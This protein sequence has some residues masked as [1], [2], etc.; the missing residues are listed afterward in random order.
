M[1]HFHAKID[2]GMV[3]W[4]PWGHFNQNRLVEPLN[5]SLQTKLQNGS[6]VLYTSTVSGVLHTHSQLQPPEA[7]H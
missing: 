6:V 3:A 4:P 2:D 5:G 7:R 1:E